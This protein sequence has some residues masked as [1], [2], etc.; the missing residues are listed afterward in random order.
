[1]DQSNIPPGGKDPWVSSPRIPKQKATNWEQN[2]IV[3]LATSALKE[4]RKSRRWSIFFKILFFAYITFIGFHLWQGYAPEIDDGSTTHTALIKISGVISSSPE[5]T[6]ARQVIQSLRDAYKSKGTAGIILEINSPGG[7]PVQAGQ[8]YDE[9]KRL[10]VMHPEIPIHSVIGDICASGGYYVAVA[11]DNIYVDKASLVG[12][13]GVRMD[14]FGF[15]DTMK[16]V[17]VERRLLT[18]GENKA[19]L[20]PFS[21]LKESE[22][23]HARTLLQSIH[24]QFIDVVKEGRGEKLKGRDDELFNGLIW[25]GAQSIDNGLTDAIGSVDYV[26]REIIKEA[27]LVDFTQKED[28]LQR[29]T[30][31]V[32]TSISGA[33]KAVLLESSSIN[34]R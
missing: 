32:G 6:N 22:R 20:D 16:L 7:S 26:A 4:Q 13:I 27:R 33:L 15:V 19:F 2:L 31:R 29:L 23:G 28:L 34:L 24:Q 1:M 14:G 18:A 9:I 30:Q 25:T 11:S 17:G 12:S 10:R 8:I 5:D 3:E 21:P